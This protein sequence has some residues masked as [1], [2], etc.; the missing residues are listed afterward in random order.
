MQPLGGS[1]VCI[2]NYYVDETSNKCLANCSLISGTV[3][4]TAP[5][6]GCTCEEGSYYTIKDG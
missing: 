4:T 6:T 3:S 2:N 5:G 1:C